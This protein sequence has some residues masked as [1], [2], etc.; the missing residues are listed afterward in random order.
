MTFAITAVVAVT[1]TS[2]YASSEQQKAQR[3]ANKQA[4][5]DS[6]DAEMR[7]RKAETFAETEGEGIGSLGKV[8]LEI[9][10]DEEVSTK[11][12]SSISI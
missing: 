11:S 6:L 9:D 12:S 7:A 10:E 2:L 5:E 1:A 8:S 4:E 3:A